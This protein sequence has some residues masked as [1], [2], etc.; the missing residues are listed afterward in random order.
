MKARAVTFTSKT[1]SCLAG[2]LFAGG[3]AAEA[4]APYDGPAIA[5]NAAPLS[6]PGVEDGCY[7][8][9]VKNASET[10]W[11]K[12]HICGHSYGAGASVS[13]VGPC[14]ASGTGLHSVELVVEGLCSGGPCVDANADGVWDN[15]MGSY[16]NPCPAGTPCIQTN[17]AC[18]ENA[19]TRV[20]FDLAVMRE[21]NQGFFDIAVSFNDIFCSAKLDCAYPGE[22]ASPDD[23]VEIRLLHDADG[24]RGRTAVIGFACTTGTGD[25]ETVLALTDVYVSCYDFD[26]SSATI[27]PDQDGNVDI[28]AMIDNGEA[29]DPPPIFAAQISR[30]TEA[31]GSGGASANMVY[32]NIMLGYNDI[33]DE[34]EDEA[35][36]SVF[37]EGT[38][39][40]G[41]DDN[42]AIPA[43]PS[44]VTYPIIVWNVV[45]TDVHGDRVCTQHPFDFNV[46]AP[47]FVDDAFDVVGVRYE[48]EPDG[49]APTGNFYRYPAA[50]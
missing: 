13:Y 37:L 32:W 3:C 22:T 2:L 10:V 17:I 41:A 35:G 33:P 23:D 4:E 18:S 1:L 36:C 44:G 39:L 42:A 28:A 26:W 9:T 48:N 31:L 25:D 45:L 24:Q 47:D 30:G 46:V 14:D 49:W 29:S 21:A 15:D 16:S 12:A 7:A 5:I 20:T 19:D 40:D 43:T 6:L 8:L 11:S 34:N 50:E 38:A 27:N